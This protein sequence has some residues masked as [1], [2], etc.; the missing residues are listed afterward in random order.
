VQHLLVS[1]D[2]LADGRMIIAQ[3]EALRT[4][5][6]ICPKRLNYLR[7]DAFRCCNFFC[8]RAA[9]NNSANPIGGRRRKPNMPIVSAGRGT[10]Q[11]EL[12]RCSPNRDE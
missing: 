5:A 8:S 10:V 11:I 7:R 4:S 12:A 9:E 1:L 6:C 2:H 3:F